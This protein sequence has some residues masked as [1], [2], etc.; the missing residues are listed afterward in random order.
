[1]LK[2]EAPSYYI[3]GLLYNVP[4]ELFTGSLDSMVLNIL[5]WFYQT[6]DR[7]NFVCANE[8]YYLLRDSSP[9]CWPTANGT[10]FISAAVSLWNNWS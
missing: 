7:S 1:M 2:G 3:E 5:T 10:K 4:N 9:V 6:T 8:R